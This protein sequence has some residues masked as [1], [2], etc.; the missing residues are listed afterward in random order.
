MI[1]ILLVLGPIIGAVLCGGM[2]YYAMNEAFRQ[3]YKAGVSVVTSDREQH[4]QSQIRVVE[5]SGEAEKTF[6]T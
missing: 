4:Y 1:E 2:V 5:E 3:G 6:G